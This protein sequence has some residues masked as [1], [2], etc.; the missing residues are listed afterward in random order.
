MATL[1]Y[2]PYTSDPITDGDLPE[3]VG[4][5]TPLPAGALA[6]YDYIFPAGP[7]STARR[8]PGGAAAAAAP[9]SNSLVPKL[10]NN[11]PDYIA[12]LDGQLGEI[13]KYRDALR[14]MGQ[15]IL[16]LRDRVRELEMENSALRRDLGSYSDASKILQDS[17]E[18]D[19]IPRAE[20]MARYAALRQNLR[21]SVAQLQQYKDKVHRLQNE[22]IA[23]N[24][25]AAGMERLAGAHESQQRLLQRLQER[26]AKQRSLE[27]ACAKQEKVIE[28]MERLLRDKRSG[29]GRD[30]EAKAK[31]LMEENR[32]LRDEM[33]AV[34]ASQQQRRNGMESSE[35]LELYQLLD[36][37]ET[38]IASLEKQIDAAA[39]KQKREKA[40]LLEDIEEA[41]RAARARQ[42]R[43]GRRDGGGGQ[44][45]NVQF[46]AVPVPFEVQGNDRQRH[47][48]AE[49]SDDDYYD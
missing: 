22:L 11:G 24:Q 4:S 3:E 12:Q 36:K 19:G 32:K 7:A 16:S 8:P 10:H 39:R 21:G 17:V 38:R 9:L 30:E 15:D 28:K 2:R 26:V 40:R 14:K 31:A 27:E 13:E 42:R 46:F 45:P 1:Y 5:S 20:L 29:A 33:T 37:A 41:E 44:Q 47:R 34:K 18:L 23:G 6:D 35:R 25:S 49:E 48:P 43:G